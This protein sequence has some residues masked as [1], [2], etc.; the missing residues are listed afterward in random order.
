MKRMTEKGPNGYYVRPDKGGA[1]MVYSPGSEPAQRFEGSIVDRLAEYENLGMEVR[2]IKKSLDRN[3]AAQSP[4]FSYGECQDVKLL[5]E[6][7]K[8]ER[9][10]S[11]FYR[12]RLAE[13]EF[14]ILPQKR[15]RIVGLNMKV[16]KLERE[17]NAANK[18]I[19]I[20]LREKDIMI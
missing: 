10:L 18:F 9:E 3:P 8:A 15:G 14:S 16:E 1:T 19:E 7:L 13:L 2:A 20:L 12:S 4:C 6:E 5:S 11:S 17:L